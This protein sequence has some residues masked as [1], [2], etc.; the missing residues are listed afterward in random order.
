MAAIVPTSLRFPPEL[1]A[2]LTS[3]AGRLG[4]S[5]SEAVRNMVSAE[6]D[7]LEWEAA[8][9]ENAARAR[10]ELDSLPTL[11]EMAERYGVELDGSDPA[12]LDDVR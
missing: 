9:L 8:I 10:A 12:L 6:L 3:V 7:R 2:R 5:K 1:D 11:N 4:V